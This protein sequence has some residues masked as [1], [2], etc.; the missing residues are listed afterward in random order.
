[1]RKFGALAVAAVILFAFAATA[2]EFDWKRHSGKSISVMLVQHP[3]AEG[4]TQKIAEFEAAT[5]STAPPFPKRT[6]STS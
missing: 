5:R 3:Y 1:M 2:G 6:I 4:I